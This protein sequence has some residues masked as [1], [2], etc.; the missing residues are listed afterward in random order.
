MSGL[1]WHNELCPEV[2]EKK[3]KL[4]TAKERTAPKKGN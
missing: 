2:D 3:K 4:T 1:P